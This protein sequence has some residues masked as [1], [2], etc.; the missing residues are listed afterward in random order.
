MISEYHRPR[1]IGE[2][3]RLLGREQPETVPISGGSLLNTEG[4]EPLAVVDLQQLGLEGIQV[5][6]S[7]LMIGATTTLQVVLENKVLQPAVVKAIEVEAGDNQRRSKTVAGAL[8]A[9]NGCSAF[10][11]AM[12]ALDAV[13]L[14][15]PGD[16]KMVLGELLP[17]RR[18]LLPGR[19]IS[20]VRLPLITALA[21]ERAWREPDE[22]PFLTVSIARWPSGRSRV[23]LGGWGAAPMMV[24][25]GKDKNDIL[26]AIESATMQAADQRASAAERSEAA[27][28]L[29]PSCLTA[30]QPSTSTATKSN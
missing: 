29:L 14:L 19:L 2:A 12:L 30:L 6:G 9:A 25:D 24:V 17:L 1:Q 5:K 11:A 21:F 27:R 13:V 20:Q 10:T 23:V 26:P 28:K 15:Q 3:L 16:E 4:D 7:S 22:A 8:V 18:N